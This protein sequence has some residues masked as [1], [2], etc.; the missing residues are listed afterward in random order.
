MKGAAKL[1][2]TGAAVA[3]ALIISYLES[4]L[5]L[6]VSVPGVRLGLANIVTL[7]VLYKLDWRYAALVSFLRVGLAALLFGSVL[8]LAYSAAGALVSLIVMVLLKKT[9]GFSAV[10]VSC[11]GAVAHNFGQI[12]MA[13]LLTD[14]VEI[15]YYLPVL[16]VSGVV[17]GLA[18]GALGALLV[19]RLN[20]KIKGN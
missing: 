9:A 17:T 19:K 15:A 18:V 12:G 10:G 14:T 11:A 2:F 16:I 1:T 13:I 5:P 20:V 3:A 7:F 8:T 4:L 6:F